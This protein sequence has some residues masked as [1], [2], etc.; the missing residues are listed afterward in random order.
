MKQALFILIVSALLLTACGQRPT[1][2]LEATI[3]AAVIATLTAWPTAT[4]TSTVTQTPAPT[5][6]ETAT[7]T[8]ATPTPEP[9]AVPTGTP[10]PPA[11][12]TPEPATPLTGT[13]V[14]P[15]TSTPEPATA[16]TD[17]PVPPPTPTREPASAPT[18]TPGATETNTPTPT[19]TPI[20][21]ATPTPIIHIVQTGDNLSKIATQYGVS[22]DALIAANDI[23][24][25]SVIEVGEKLLIPSPTATGVVSAPQ[26]ASNPPPEELPDEVKALV[27]ET[28][29]KSDPSLR[30]KGVRIFREEGKETILIVIETQGGQGSIADGTTL[31]EATTGFIYAYEGDQKL[32]IAARYVLVQAQNQPGQDVWYA[33]ATLNDIGMLARGEITA[34]TFVQRIVVDTP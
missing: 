27:I 20:P 21:T 7:S 3:Q 24:D 19:F 22:V 14:S 23:R 15:P 30:V 26:A 17:T 6:T 34:Q 9:T 4:P 25:R 32:K 5:P 10:V 13:P 11:T 31:R 16:S 33:V 28:A 8:P 2:D 12:S 29:L 1:P 18:D